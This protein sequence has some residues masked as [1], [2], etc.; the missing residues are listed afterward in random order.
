[1]ESLEAKRVGVAATVEC[2]V[3]TR[4]APGRAPAPPPTHLIPNDVGTTEPR[5][6]AG[7]G[8][9]PSAD[10]D[11]ARP[12]GRHSSMTDPTMLPFLLLV[13]RVPARVTEPLG[14]A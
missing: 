6:S 3:V 11:V 8:T 7:T 1:M 5:I 2:R 9:P 10:P 4:P 14:A 12:L 13:T